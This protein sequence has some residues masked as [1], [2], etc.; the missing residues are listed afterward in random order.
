[1]SD[2]IEDEV[3]DA[4]A[5]ESEDEGAGAA[6]EEFVGSRAASDVTLDHHA[7]ARATEIGMDDDTIRATLQ[8]L[9]MVRATLGP[10]DEMVASMCTDFESTLR[11]LVL[12]WSKFPERPLVR[13]LRTMD[14][15]KRDR[16]I[17]RIFETFHELGWLDADLA[18]VMD[19]RNT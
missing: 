19:A 13:T 17:D 14:A 12:E 5:D 1:M 7:L 11:T 4:D 18:H 15:S 3:V 10:K 16:S 9:E 6:I 2:D 8:T